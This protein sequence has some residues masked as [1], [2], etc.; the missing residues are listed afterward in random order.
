METHSAK[1]LSRRTEWRISDG[2]LTETSPDS[3]QFT[4]TATDTMT[5]LKLLYKCR[6]SIA[7]AVLKEQQA[8]RATADA[9]VDSEGELSESGLP[10]YQTS[11]VEIAEELKHKQPGF[12]SP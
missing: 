7:Q 9:I 1:S 4:L 2:R 10:S 11:T 3:F 12:I 8:Q 6:Q 5:L